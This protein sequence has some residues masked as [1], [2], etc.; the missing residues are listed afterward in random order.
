MDSKASPVVKP[1]VNLGLPEVTGLSLPEVADPVVTDPVVT[2]PEVAG[3][4]VNEPV[5]NLLYLSVDIFF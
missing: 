1:V 3:E 4:V 2:E 5:V